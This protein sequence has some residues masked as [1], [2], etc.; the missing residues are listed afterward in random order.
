M[1]YWRNIKKSLGEIEY[2]MNGKPPN[3]TPI[4]P[5]FSPQT[6]PTVG[7]IIYNGSGKIS[8]IC[9]GDKVVS[10]AEGGIEDAYSMNNE[11]L[12]L[13][14]YGYGVIA[15][16]GAER[17]SHSLYKTCTFSFKDNDV[18]TLP[19]VVSFL[20]IANKLGEK[21]DFR[22][23]VKISA[24][25][26]RCLT[27]RELFEV[28]LKDFLLGDVK[29]EYEEIVR[30]HDKYLILKE[31]G[32]QSGQ[33]IVLLPEGSSVIYDKKEKAFLI[34]AA[35]GLKPK[36]TKAIRICFVFDVPEVGNTLREYV[37]YL[38][39]SQRERMR[40]IIAFFTPE[41][42]EA[43]LSENIK[44]MLPL[45]EAENFSSEQKSFF[46]NSLNIF[47][48]ILEID[49]DGRMSV[50]ECLDYVYSNS[51]DVL[52]LVRDLLMNM[53]PDEV[54]K[55]LLW[56]CQSLDKESTQIIIYNVT[57]NVRRDFTAMPWYKQFFIQGLFFRY[58]PLGRKIAEILKS[59]ET[60]AEKMSRLRKP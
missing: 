38:G 50:A 12:Q 24:Q 11:V 26:I 18:R 5:G 30:N 4:D 17:D 46:A 54:R 28:E 53:L 39:D 59:K 16:F 19:H 15:I 55:E 42:M 1:V 34:E 40:N 13:K 56:T 21:A 10:F 32:N 14:A 27:T 49:K 29:V 41:K 52:T 36:E 51:K 35:I 58:T 57:G 60:S 22:Y 47:Y 20:E 6:G 44:E 25:L 37:K 48:P 23:R 9:L 2:P 45:A 31:K 43:I 33:V 7:K 3:M 8:R